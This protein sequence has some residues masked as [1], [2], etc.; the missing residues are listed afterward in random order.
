MTLPPVVE[1]DRTI[2]CAI[3]ELADQWIF[4]G[5]QC[6]RR[7]IETDT[8]IGNHDGAI[9][10]RQGFIDMMSNHQTAQTETVIEPPNQIQHHAT[11]NRIQPCQRFV[12][13]HDRRV[14]YQCTRQGN[15][16][17]HATRQFLR[18]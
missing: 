14:E 13:K 4:A 11:G 16:A 8:A 15:A 10:V 3:E 7:A 1:A 9:R 5:L 18:R 6:V 12:V 2:R 17:R